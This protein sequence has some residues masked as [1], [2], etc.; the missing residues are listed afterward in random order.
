MYEETQKI[1]TDGN[2]LLYRCENVDEEY[3]YCFCC[4]GLW[5]GSEYLCGNNFSGNECRHGR[6]R[7]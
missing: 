5:N 6:R 4:R 7:V 3:K 2:G 1:E